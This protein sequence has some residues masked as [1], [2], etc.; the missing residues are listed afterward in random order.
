MP[1][2]SY[3]TNISKMLDLGH[4]EGA[5]GAEA[6]CTFDYSYDRNFHCLAEYSWNQSEMSLDSFKDRYIRKYFPNHYEKAKKAFEAFDCF[7]EPSK[8]HT[9]MFITLSY[10]S[11]SYVR[12]DKEYPRN[13]PGTVF[14]TIYQDI[15]YYN[16][17]LNEVYEESSQAYDLFDELSESVL[18]HN[19]LLEHYKIECLHYKVLSNE[20]LKLI[21]IN[22]KYN[23]M[24]G[25]KENIFR[26]LNTIKE[27]INQLISERKRF[28]LIFEKVKD[29]YLVP[30]NLKNSTIHLQ[31]LLDFRLHIEK[32]GF[33]IE[34]GNKL[35]SQ[36]LINFSDTRSI[37]SK[38]FMLLR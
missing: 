23:D 7:V 26:N 14:E 10:Y 8:K 30:F 9:L 5:E 38:M 25:S 2:A 6:Y 13:F 12:K 31:Y 36:S 27:S 35:E 18:C 11:Y 24:A 19:R 21:D 4:R 16:K 28:M 33:E 15:E 17:L 3:L 34:S 37:S 1:T 20:Y 29:P 22:E 32:I